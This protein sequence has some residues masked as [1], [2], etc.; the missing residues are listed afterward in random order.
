MSDNKETDINIYTNNERY[1]DGINGLPR[2]GKT[3]DPKAA[4]K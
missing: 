4:R 3:C 2:V 1:F